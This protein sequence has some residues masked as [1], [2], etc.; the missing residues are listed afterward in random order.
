MA[1]MMETWFWWQWQLY[2]IMA[3][4]TKDH[5]IIGMVWTYGAAENHLWFLDVTHWK[6][7]SCMINLAWRRASSSSF[8]LRYFLVGYWGFVCEYLN[9]KNVNFIHSFPVLPHLFTIIVMVGFSSYYVWDTWLHICRHCSPVYNF[10]HISVT[11][12][13]LFSTVWFFYIL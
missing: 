12:F 5:A 10:H 2:L 3:T 1:H 6:T 13:I 7:A 8:L 9:Q 4:T 11:G